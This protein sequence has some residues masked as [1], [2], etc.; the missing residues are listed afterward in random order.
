[1]KNNGFPVLRSYLPFTYS[2][3]YVF[4]RKAKRRRWTATA[5]ETEDSLHNE[6]STYRED[7]RQRETF[8]EDTLKKK[9]LQR[10]GEKRGISLT[11]F[12]PGLPINLTERVSDRTSSEDE[13]AVSNNE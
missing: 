9:R 11:L 8:L 10:E 4:S 12:L 6:V 7:G 1:M 5:D 13:E 2:V 3:R